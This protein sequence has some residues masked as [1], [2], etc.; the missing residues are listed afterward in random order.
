MSLGKDTSAT[1]RA[2]HALGSLGY[3]HA[4]SLAAGRDLAPQTRLLVDLGRSPGQVPAALVDT[5]VRTIV[6][7]DSAFGHGMATFLFL[8]FGFPVAQGEIDRR[9]LA[10]GVDARFAPMYQ[11]SL[12]SSWAARGAWDSAY[13]ARW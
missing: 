7:G 13:V 12:A 9:V 1:R 4:L 5:V 10:G 3:G 8:R 2:V 6:Q 11:R